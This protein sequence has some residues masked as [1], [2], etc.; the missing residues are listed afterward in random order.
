MLP[1]GFSRLQKQIP[2]K[3]QMLYSCAHMATVG[4]KGLE[5]RQNET[6][7]LVNWP[8][9]AW[10]SP[11]TETVCP[12]HRHTYSRPL[13]TH[14]RTRHRRSA[15]AA[16]RLWTAGRS[17]A[18]APCRGTAACRPAETGWTRRHWTLSAVLAWNAGHHGIHLRQPTGAVI[19]H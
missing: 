7:L 5:I 4:E 3:L 9:C 6:M 19:S 18:A 10:A 2:T 14:Q 1:N 8:S 16:G 13:Q 17:V 12:T 11:C 15:S